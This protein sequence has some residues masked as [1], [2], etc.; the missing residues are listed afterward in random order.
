MLERKS[1]TAIDIAKIFEQ[2]LAIFVQVK[3]SLEQLMSNYTAINV[4]I[5]SITAIDVAKI[6]EQ[7][8]TIFVQV[9]GNTTPIHVES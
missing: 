1:I 3:G 5:K 4:K 7:F 9:K 2:V 8:L 6:F